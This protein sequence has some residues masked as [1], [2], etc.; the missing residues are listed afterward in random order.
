MYVI[1]QREKT[2]RADLAY[3]LRDTGGRTCNLRGDI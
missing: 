1:R 2:G 3:S